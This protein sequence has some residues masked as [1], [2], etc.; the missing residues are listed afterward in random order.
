[1]KVVPK[2]IKDQHLSFV[3]MMIPF[4]EQLNEKLYL[5][6]KPSPFGFKKC[7]SKPEHIDMR[8]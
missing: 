5:P 3:E 6:C 8:F 4:T 2:I 1:M 7:I